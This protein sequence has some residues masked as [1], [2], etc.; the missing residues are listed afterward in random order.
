MS[1]N[2]IIGSR[3]NRLVKK[4]AD[5]SSTSSHELIEE[6]LNYYGV[7]GVQELSEKKIEDFCRM[8]GL[9]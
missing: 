5:A 4:L 2:K 9:T 6:C 3:K 1:T 8:K 7:Y